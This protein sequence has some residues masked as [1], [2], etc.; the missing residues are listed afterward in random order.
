MVRV[1]FDLEKRTLS[2]QGHAG[3]DVRGKDIVCA[4]VSALTQ[5]FANMALGLEGRI[6]DRE[7]GRLKVAYTEKLDYCAKV[8]LTVLK[9]IEQQYPGNLKVEVRT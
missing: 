3:F 7:E 6:T 5:Y 1:R 4:A 9:D 2:V 8:L